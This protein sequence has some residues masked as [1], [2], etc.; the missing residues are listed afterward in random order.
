MEKSMRDL[1]P[2][3]YKKLCE[4]FDVAS[5]DKFKVTDFISDSKKRNVHQIIMA[6]LLICSQCRQWEVR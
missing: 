1:E 4:R 2:E 6:I 3:Q 5:V